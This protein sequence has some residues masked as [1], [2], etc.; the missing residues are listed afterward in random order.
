V[1]GGSPPNQKALQRQARP[2]GAPV[3]L[4]LG[5][6]PFPQIHSVSALFFSISCFYL[7]SREWI[8]FGI[9]KLA[10][11]IVAFPGLTM[12]FSGL[13]WFFPDIFHRGVATLLP[14]HNSSDVATIEPWSIVPF[15]KLLWQ[16]FTHATIDRDLPQFIDRTAGHHS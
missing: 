16:H 2:K 14:C 5:S 3:L 13:L 1:E 7:V 4:L 8:A 6:W 11:W 12:A 9:N 10:L 15:S